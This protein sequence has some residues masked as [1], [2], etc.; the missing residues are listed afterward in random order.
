MPKY[1]L[2]I[3]VK[4]RLKEIKEYSNKEFGKARTKLYLKSLKNRMAFLAKEPEKGKKR[5]DI[6]TDW[7]CYSY[8]ESSHTIYY[9]PYSDHIVIIDIL[10]QTMQPTKEWARNNFPV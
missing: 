1:I 10:H 9:E 6:T 2:T 7:E 5:D 4:N 3:Q 8:F